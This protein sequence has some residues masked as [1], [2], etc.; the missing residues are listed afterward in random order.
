MSNHFPCLFTK[1]AQPKCW[2]ADDHHSSKFKVPQF[3]TFRTFYPC[4]GENDLCG[5]AF[6]PNNHRTQLPALEFCKKSLVRA[7]HST[8]SH[9]SSSLPDMAL[10]WFNSALFFS[11]LLKFLERAPTKWRSSIGIGKIKTN[12]RCLLIV[13]LV[14]VQSCTAFKSWCSSAR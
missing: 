12:M 10:V 8:I 14:Y 1:L 11:S 5:L 4:A 13:F 9:S 7:H 2:L 6:V 3:R